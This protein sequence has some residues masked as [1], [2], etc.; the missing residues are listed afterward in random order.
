LTVRGESRPKRCEVFD[1]SCVAL[2]CESAGFAQREGPV[3]LLRGKSQD[4]I[5]VCPRHGKD[6]IGISGYPRRELSCGE[7]GNIT[8][9]L[10]EDARS[11]GLNRMPC[12][13]VGTGT[14]CCEILNMGSSAVCDSESFRRRGTTNVSSADEQYV[15]SKLLL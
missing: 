10:L 7:I 9:Q 3:E 4:V 8:T 1:I 6:K 15:Q 14:R 11:E 2:R 5:A 13:G 12:H